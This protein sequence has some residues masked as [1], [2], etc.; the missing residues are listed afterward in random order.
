MEFDLET[1]ARNPTLQQLHKCRKVDLMLIANVFTTGVALNLK[2]EELLQFLVVKLVKEVRLP[3]QRR[4]KKAICKSETRSS[5][6]FCTQ[7]GKPQ[8]DAEKCCDSRLY[9]KK[10]D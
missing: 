3:L 2:K 8:K 9:N 6:S 5:T 4:L 7:T 10:I 1:M